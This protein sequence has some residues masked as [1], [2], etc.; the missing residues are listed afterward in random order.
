[1]TNSTQLADKIGTS[2]TDDEVKCICSCTK[3]GC[4]Y[5]VCGMCVN[6][7]K[8]IRVCLCGYCYISNL[9]CSILCGS[10][11]KDG[12]VPCP[13]C[14]FRDVKAARNK[15][16]NHCCC[17]SC[18]CFCPNLQEGDNEM[19]DPLTDSEACCQFFKTLIC[20]CPCTVNH[21]LYALCGWR[22]QADPI[23]ML[24]CAQG[25]VNMCPCN[26]CPSYCGFDLNANPWCHMESAQGLAKRKEIH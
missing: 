20:C 6:P 18:C 26:L 15:N 8:S 16:V 25:K 22:D 17:A 24:C 12:C 9:A 1:M 23:S 19:N 14:E 4:C 5:P 2:R 3:G 7:C 11:F 10:C 13:L 21:Y